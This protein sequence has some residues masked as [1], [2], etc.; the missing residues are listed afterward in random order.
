[1]A[2]TF[3]SMLRRVIF[4]KLC[5]VGEDITQ[6]IHFVHVFYAFKTHMFYSHRNHDDNVR[7]IPFVMGTSQGDP[8]G[9]VLFALAQFRALHFI[10]NHFPLIYF[11]PLQMTFTSSSPLPL[12]PLH[13]NTFRLN[14]M[15]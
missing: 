10:V 14:F 7:V 5:I 15:R 11:H 1:V 6:L 13:M 3:N 8:L 2:N 4:Q 12:Y 9:V